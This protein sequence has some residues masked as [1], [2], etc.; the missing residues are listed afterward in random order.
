MELRRHHE[1]GGHYEPGCTM[2]HW[3]SAVF[4]WILKQGACL[5]QKCFRT[6]NFFL[7][8]DWQ[9]NNT[10]I[11]YCVVLWSGPRSSGVVDRVVLGSGPRSSGIVDRVVL[12]SE[13][14]GSGVVARVVLGSGQRSSGVVDRVVLGSGQRSSGVVDRIVLGSLTA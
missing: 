12:G 14:R 4:T 9:C 1:P 11:W 3:C 13:T 8:T 10:A 6:S 2:Q 5:V 7:K